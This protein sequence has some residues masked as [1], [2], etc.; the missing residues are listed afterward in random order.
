MRR[1]MRL[2]CQLTYMYMYGPIFPVRGGGGG[3][4]HFH[5][6]QWWGR[7]AGQGMIFLTSPLTQ[8]NWPIGYWRATPFI[9]GLLP[10]PQCLWQA[11]N[12][13]PATAAQPLPCLFSR[14]VG[15][16]IRGGPT[17]DEQLELVNDGR[18][19]SDIFHFSGVIPFRGVL[20]GMDDRNQTSH[21][22]THIKTHAQNTHT[23]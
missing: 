20:R 19:A 3:G 16:H 2:T 7:A 9:T 14:D 6:W 22:N 10:S 4:G 17:P 18:Q 12:S 13:A 15:E 11:W 23:I 1:G 8:D 21:A 5:Y